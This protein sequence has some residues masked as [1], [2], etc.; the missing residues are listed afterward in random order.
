[1]MDD[2]LNKPQ[3]TIR[4]IPWITIIA[5]VVMVYIAFWL[6]IIKK[7]SLAVSLFSILFILIIVLFVEV[8][9]CTFD[10][11]LKKTTIVRQ[12][13]WRRRTDEFQYND[14]HTI[15][16]QESSST[17]GG[18][19]TY[20]IVFFMRDGK[21]IPLTKQHESGK[22]KKDKLARK[23]TAYLQAQ[24]GYNINLALDG[25]V[26]IQQPVHPSHQ[27]WLITSIFRNDVPPIT[28]F[29]TALSEPFSGFILIV[30]AALNTTSKIPGG[31]GGKIIS[32]FYN[33]YF[34]TMDISTEE[35][36]NLENSAV[37]QGP[38]VGLSKGFA[39]VT[40]QPDWA[41]KW[42]SGKRAQN[43]VHWQKENPLGGKP[44]IVEPHIFINHTGLKV[45]FRENYYQ[46]EKISIIIQFLNQLI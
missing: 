31:L 35:I 12:R 41:R 22:R 17:D 37:L 27:N 9:T 1:M 16:V 23:I 10:S 18:S 43:L 2:H 21:L 32:K 38:E 5:P 6:I 15:A 3:W 33:A 40:N 4:Q 8:T 39:V 13:I 28:R 30:P 29:E 42:L 7:S 44:V 25:I 36:N 11:Y 24:C 20:R 46:P 26:R 45:V 19:P 34:R 14:V